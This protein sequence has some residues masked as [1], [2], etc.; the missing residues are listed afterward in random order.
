MLG[1]KLNPEIEFKTDNK[2]STLV[3]VFLILAA[4]SFYVFYINGVKDN[5]DLTKNALLKKQEEVSVI[6]TRL[7]EFKKAENELDI[8]TAVQRNEV[9]KSIP[10]GINQDELIKDMIEISDIHDIRLNSLSFGKGSLGED[11]VGSVR[12]NSSF[13]G[14]YTDLV[15]FIEGIEQNSRFLKIE[16]ISVQLNKLEIS[17][18]TRATFS[19]S[20]QAF[21]QKN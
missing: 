14:S 8:T 15:A 2:T 9:S 18:G 19:L 3:G 20:M 16:S 1:E 7:A 4:V 6:Q 21:Y 11:G 13:E 12:I 5:F 17:D 10:L